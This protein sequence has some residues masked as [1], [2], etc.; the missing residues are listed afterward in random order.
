MNNLLVAI[1]VFVITV[2][3]ALFAVP[4][5]VDWNS[6]RSN[7]EEE[8]SRV[9]GREVQV[10]GDVNAA[11]AADPLF[12]PGEGAHRRCVG[13]AHLLQGRK[14]EHQAVHSADVPRHRGGQRDRV[15]APDPAAGPRRQGHLELAELCAGAGLGRLHAIQRHADLAQDHR[16]RACLARPRRRRA[17]KARRLQRRTVGARARRALPL[18]R[19][20]RLRRRRARD[21]ARDRP[22]R[23]RRRGTPARVPAPGGYGRHLPAGRA[24]CST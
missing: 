11:P 3:G 13:G 6:Y 17:G 2:V 10:D 14:P 4:Y 5:F 1:A 8:A 19:H 9:I 15:P 16:R 21:Q 23:G 20:V 18:P 24:R 22:A 7:F 12:P